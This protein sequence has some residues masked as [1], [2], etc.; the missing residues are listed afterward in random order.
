MRTGE[1]T[2][3]GE[4]FYKEIISRLWSDVKVIRINRGTGRVMRTGENAKLTK[5]TYKE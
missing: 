5:S 2:K 1:E 4:T 3:L